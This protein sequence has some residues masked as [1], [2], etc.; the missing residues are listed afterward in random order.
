MKCKMP[1][2]AVKDYKSK[3]CLLIDMSVPID[4]S[5][6]KNIIFKYKDMEIEIEKKM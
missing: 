3:I 1:G 4:F 6:S 5:I 2:I